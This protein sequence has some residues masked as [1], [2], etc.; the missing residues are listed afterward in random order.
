MAETRTGFEDIGTIEDPDGVVAVL[1]RRKSSGA[2]TAAFF[3]V[4]ERD[5]SREKTNFLP[6]SLF[7]ALQRVMV[8]VEAKIA[9][10]PKPTSPHQR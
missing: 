7:P 6:V 5:G 4:F 8:L 9:S 3:K 2:V 1:S 10:L